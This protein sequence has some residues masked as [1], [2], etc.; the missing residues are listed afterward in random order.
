MKIRPEGAE[1]SHADGWTDTQDE[2]NSRL[3]SI[4]RTR[5]K[6]GGGDYGRTTSVPV[7]YQVSRQD[8]DIAANILSD[9]TT[10]R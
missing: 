9:G 6:I 2:R 7:L 1:L 5:L 8:G 10:W 4:L 3:F